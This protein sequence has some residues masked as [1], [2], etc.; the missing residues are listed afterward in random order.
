[1]QG[2]VWQEDTVGTVGRC[3][4]SPEHCPVGIIKTDAAFVLVRDT[5]VHHCSTELELHFTILDKSMV[6]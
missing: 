4:P 2:W 3:M 5:K 1:M 6:F